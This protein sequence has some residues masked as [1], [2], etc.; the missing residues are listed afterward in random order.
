MLFR[1]GQFWALLLFLCLW[2]Y[3]QQFAFAAMERLC[4][5][6][7]FSIMFM[8]KY[9]SGRL[10]WGGLEQIAGTLC[11]RSGPQVAGGHFQ[12][13]LT[14]RETTGSNFLLKS[15]SAALSQISVNHTDRLLSDPKLKSDSL[16][17]LSPYCI[18]KFGW[19]GLF[20]TCGLRFIRFLLTYA[21]TEPGLS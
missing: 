2:F 19:F 11:V 21:W 14:L 15:L 18:T 1:S 7:G 4:Y 8:W 17:C 5:V 10:F 12:L 20:V 13:K 9:Y 16:L 6:K 3:P